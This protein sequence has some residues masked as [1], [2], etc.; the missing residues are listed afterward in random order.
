MLFIGA[1]TG[2][3]GP[4][5]VKQ[6][7]LR[8]QEQN[9]GEEPMIA[10][11]KARRLHGAVNLEERRKKLGQYYTLTWNDSTG[12]GKN[13]AKLIFQYQ[14]GATGSRVKRMTQT[15]S[16]NSVRGSAEFAVIGDDYFKGGKVLAWKATLM[17]GEQ[18][19]ASQQSYL[20]R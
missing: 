5:V 19:I 18:E 2:P 1:C 4:L 8:D 3:Q 10:M 15:F 7:T 17:R 14:Q 9:R 16:E 12:S 20:W 13:K 11:E 6:F